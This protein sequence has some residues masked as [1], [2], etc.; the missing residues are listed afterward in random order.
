MQPFAGKDNEQLKGY[1][2]IISSESFQM[3]IIP[4]VDMSWKEKNEENRQEL[5]EDMGKK[6][7]G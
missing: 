1:E 5:L 7:Q 2:S 3:W 4:W 6:T